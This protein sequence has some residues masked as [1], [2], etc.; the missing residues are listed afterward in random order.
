MKKFHYWLPVSCAFAAIL[1]LASTCLLTV[2]V[3]RSMYQLGDTGQEIA[4]I[5]GTPLLINGVASQSN[6]TWYHWAY[7]TNRNAFPVN[8][9]NPTLSICVK[10][11]ID[12]LHLF[13]GVG[14]QPPTDP[15]ETGMLQNLC[16][17]LTVNQDCQQR[18][19]FIG[20][21]AVNHTTS[22]FTLSVVLGLSDSNGC[23]V[24]VEGTFW[25]F[26]GLGAL[27]T[28]TTFIIATVTF[29]CEYLVGISK[30]TRTYSVIKDVQ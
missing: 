27:L 26:L 1:S 17:N 11:G 5:V 28:A 3:V 7:N 13:A 14:S 25:F 24:I 19:A 8:L 10:E 2:L 15:I 20:V 18:T 16:Y 22:P 4:L 21:Q 29:F 23:P 30:T 6:V 9:Q 12:S